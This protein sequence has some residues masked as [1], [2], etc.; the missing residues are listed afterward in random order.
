MT[1]LECT[2]PAPPSRPHDLEQCP[3][4]A[5]L[6]AASLKLRVSQRHHLLLNIKP[7][8]Y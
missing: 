6:M 4:V 1:S 3:Y 5:H 7:D 2:Q 8:I